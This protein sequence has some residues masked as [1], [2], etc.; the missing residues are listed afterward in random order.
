M[1][2][3]DQAAQQ[4]RE[5]LHTISD[6]HIAI[7]LLHW[8]QQTYMPKG[9]ISTRA[10]TIAT[11]SNLAHRMS[12]DTD[13]HRMVDAVTDRF[14]PETDDG[15]LARLARRNFDRATRLPA[16]L[17]TDLARTTALAEPAWVEARSRGEW[18]TFA[19][20]LFRIVELQK[21]V[22]ES[23]GYTT[24]PYD[25]LLD[26]YEPDATKAQLEI[27]FDELKHAI[28]PLVR[29]IA[30]K[31]DLPID[32]ARPL[33][34]TFDEVKQETFGR[35]CIT[36]FGYDW[37]HGRQD[38]TVHPFCISFTSQDVRITTRFDT[39]FLQ[40]AL[41]GT[42]HEAGHA[43]YEQ[44]VNPGYVRTPLGS[45]VS[46]GVHESQSRLWE[47]LIGRSRAFW[48]YFYPQLQQVF[49]EALG[50]TNLDAFYRAVNT[51]AP[52]L[53]RVEADEV[54]YNL[55]TLLRFELEVALL[56]GTLTIAELPDAWNAKSKEY[57]G[58]SPTSD[59]DG[60][61]QDIHWSGGMFAYFPTYTIGN[62][63]AVQLF[64]AATKA[65]PTIMDEAARG[66]FTSLH[67]WLKNNI[68]Q[69]GSKYKPQDLIERA[70]GSRMNTAPYIRYLREKFGELYSLDR[71][72]T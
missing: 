65:H 24:H 18:N 33:Y 38:R 59:A 3:A 39:N 36:R 50:N 61:L 70:T 27:M 25:A 45:G 1:N 56:D 64:D 30:A 7:A 41:F 60:A 19:P 20:H 17:V 21:Q 43:M 29:D 14:D 22:A 34:N 52:S 40:P 28:V 8:D 54:T 46:M 62:V 44:G 58:I 63:L 13:M 23:Y 49:P 37:Q 2:T 72:T 31:S 47:N 10:E 42:M 69:Y 55:H 12:T 4:L 32:R 11:L 66:E 48:T 9:G 53:I 51:V 16:E 57:L 26:E 15:A 68:Y 67:T 6:M 35:D 5:R 71:E